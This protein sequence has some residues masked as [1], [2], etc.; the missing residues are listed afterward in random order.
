MIRQRLMLNGWR[1]QNMLVCKNR[2]LIM[3]LMTREKLPNRNKKKR[4]KLRTR[5]RRKP[6]KNFMTR[7][8]R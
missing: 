7:K 2:K 5:R 3:P 1:V 4:K 6:S 8:N